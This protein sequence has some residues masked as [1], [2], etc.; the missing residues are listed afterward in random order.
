MYRIFSLRLTKHSIKRYEKPKKKQREQKYDLLILL[1]LRP[2]LK[3]EATSDQQ[4][5]QQQQ[6][7]SLT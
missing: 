5:Q 1:C 7:Q 4:Q 6:Q 2:C 3:F